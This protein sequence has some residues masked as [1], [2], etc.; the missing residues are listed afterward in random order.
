ML[1]ILGK[2][3]V[4]PHIWV[5]FM[6]VEFGRIAMQM[7]DQLFLVVLPLYKQSDCLNIMVSILMCMISPDEDIF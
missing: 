3:V 5:A 6:N 7:L 4:I 2:M 1:S